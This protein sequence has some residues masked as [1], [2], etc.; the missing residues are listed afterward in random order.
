MPQVTIGDVIVTADQGALSFV[1]R[2]QSTPLLRFDAGEAGKLM[3]FLQ[4]YVKTELN[5][6]SAFRVPVW[7]ASGLSAKLTAN[8]KVH[9]VKPLD[10]SLSGMSFE[11]VSANAPALPDGADVEITLTFESNKLTLPAVVRRREANEYGIVFPDSM[12]NDDL[13]P[14]WQLVSIVMELQRRLVAPRS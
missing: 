1:R 11:F 14:P 9:A 10:I 5:Q 7:P 4:S 12:R 8:Q 2:D 6:R 3:T 13:D